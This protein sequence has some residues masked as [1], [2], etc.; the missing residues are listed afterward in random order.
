MTRHR[1]FGAGL[2][3][4]YLGGVLAS[5]GQDVSAV[6]R[7]HVIEKLGGG[8]R[9]TDLEGH[10]AETDGLVFIRA[11]DPVEFVYTFPSLVCPSLSRNNAA[12]IA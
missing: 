4:G 11:G 12:T 3:G 10:R 8:M 1:I 9:L 7:D 5:A 6:A 2:V